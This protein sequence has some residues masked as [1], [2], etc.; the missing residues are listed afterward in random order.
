MIIHSESSSIIEN[1]VFTNSS[2]VLFSQTSEIETF[3]VFST[4]SYIDVFSSDISILSSLDIKST[5]VISQI[6]S[7]SETF[8]IPNLSKTSSILMAHSVYSS[9]FS[10]QASPGITFHTFSS[11]TLLVSSSYSSISVFNTR[12][13][14]SIEIKFDFRMA[15]KIEFID[16]LKNSFSS[17]YKKLENVVVEQLTKIFRNI[18]GF[19]KVVVI[20]FEKG[21]VLI[22]CRIIF[23]KNE[24]K[25]SDSVVQAE[26]IN[27]FMNHLKSSNDTVGGYP[28]D[29]KSVKVERTVDVRI[30]SK[31]S[32][33]IIIMVVALILLLALSVVILLQRVS[34][35]FFFCLLLL[36][37]PRS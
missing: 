14:A 35:F 23:D 33:W 6:N 18:E 15:F 26:V 12:I 7:F 36:W 3:T 2:L 22:N 31:V 4:F 32:T 25:V 1:A 24:V 17:E 34:L 10:I 5:S 19:N 37:L 11:Q 8:Y 16:S 9:P 21:S 27:N 13:L 28:V 29:I 30:S 20:G